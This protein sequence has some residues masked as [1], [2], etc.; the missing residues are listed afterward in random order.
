MFVVIVK[1]ETA[2][3]KVG[4][5]LKVADTMTPQLPVPPPRKAQKTLKRQCYS[6]T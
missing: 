1:K 2:A 4:T 6:K 5:V 3:S